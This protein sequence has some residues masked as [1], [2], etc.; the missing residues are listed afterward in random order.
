MRLRHQALLWRCVL[1]VL[2]LALVLAAL[3]CP[4]TQEGTG[5]GVPVATPTGKAGEGPPS[6]TAA[7]TALRIAMVPKLIGIPFFNACEKGAKE[8]AAE[9]KVELVFDGP[10]ESRS[11]RQ[12][13]MVDAYVDKK[14][15][16]V[17]VACNDPDAIAPSL[18]RAMQQGVTAITWDSDANPKSSGRAFFVSQATPQSIGYALVDELAR[19]AGDDAQ[20]AIISGTPTAT[21]QNQWM[22]YMRERVRE[23]YPGM[24]EVKVEYPGED[25]V[26]AMQA[27]QDLL[28]AYPELNGMFGITSVSFPGAV[29]AVV[30]AGKQAEVKVVGLATP[31]DMR[32]WVMNGDIESVILWNAVDLGYLTVHVAKAVREGTLKPGA[33]SFEAGRLGTVKVDGDQVILGD[34]LVFTKENIGDY[35]F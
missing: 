28:K 18:A 24:R 6:G 33:T 26:K 29:E 19:Q 27:A 15:D 20:F 21:N 23:K 11:E 3:G 9:L 35:D 4:K 14:M 1:V 34:P 2:L 13:E 12:A 5:A 25:R 7:G 17:A 16:V 22:E 8:A 31:N 30:K 32:Q 10:T